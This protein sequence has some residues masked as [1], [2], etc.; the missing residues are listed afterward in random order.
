MN[1]NFLPLSA[2]LNASIAEG[3][4]NGCSTLA[5]NSFDA[6]IVSVDSSNS[7]LEKKIISKGMI[8]IIIIT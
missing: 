7:Y 1:I 5:V 3:G 6:D 4:I 2:V 8:H